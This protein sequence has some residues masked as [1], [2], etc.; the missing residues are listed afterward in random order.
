MKKIA[1]TIVV[2]LI[3]LN[4]HG[5]DLKQLMKSGDSL[6]YLRVYDKAAIIYKN[7]VRDVLNGKF[8]ADDNQ[9]RRIVYNAG[10]SG[11]KSGESETSVPY[12]NMYYGSE[13]EKLLEKIDFLNR[14][15]A[16]FIYTYNPYAGG[17]TK[18]IV[19]DG[20]T[21][22][23]KKYLL[24][25]GSSYWYVQAFD[26]CHS[27]KPIKFPSIKLYNL[28]STSQNLLLTETISDLDIN[29]SNDLR[30]EYEFY[31]K[32]R[33]VTK[34][35]YQADITV[36]PS[37]SKELSILKERKN[38]EPYEKNL[39]AKITFLQS[40]SESLVVK[41]QDSLSSITERQKVGKL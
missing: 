38:L 15:G 40:I 5:Q 9:W 12:N 29:N 11:W 24:W 17:G 36:Y 1:L 18:E 21:T 14:F 20:C 16:K 13:G 39:K 7:L 33:K 30:Y 23:Q 8:K 41:Y 3:M 19:I 28:F 35:F 27:Y 4:S 26:E 6:I 31:S 25:Y 37:D 10:M 32:D 34:A 2:A 22:N